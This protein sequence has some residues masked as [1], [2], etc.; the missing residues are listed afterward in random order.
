ME[1][2]T[3]AMQMFENGQ[4]K[5]ALN[6]LQKLENNAT[7]EATFDIATLYQQYGFFEEAIKLLEK[8]LKQ[9]PNEGQI[10]VLLASLYIELEQ[11]DLAIHLLN[12]INNTD[13]FYGQSL[14]LQADIYQSQG[15]FEV[16]EQKLLE[17]KDKMPD[18]F[19]IGRET[20][21]KKV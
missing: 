12:Q 18:E 10:L 16:S 1:K 13:D 3:E 20:C 7:D 17:A 4:T 14:L 2:L 8:L 15:L 6:I 5:G 21:K 19:E 11:D 9:Y